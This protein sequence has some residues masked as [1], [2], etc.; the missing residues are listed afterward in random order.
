[1]VWNIFL[2][3][4][5][6]GIIPTDFHIFPRGRYTTN[7]RLM[8]FWGPYGQTYVCLFMDPGDEK[9][10]AAAVSRSAYQAMRNT[11]AWDMQHAMTTNH[12][13]SPCGKYW[14]HFTKNLWPQITTTCYDQYNDHKNAVLLGI[15]CCFVMRHVIFCAPLCTEASPRSPSNFEI[16]GL[17][18]IQKTMENHHF[19]WE[20]SL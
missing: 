11:D 2:F 20:N 15:C 17:V 19:S 16:P 10:S 13:K 12:H 1:V 7:Q 4:R 6:L 3:F 8:K 14:F 5:I 18:N 9:F